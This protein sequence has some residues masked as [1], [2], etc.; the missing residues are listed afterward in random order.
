MRTSKC[1]SRRSISKILSTVVPR[2]PAEFFPLIEWFPLRT[3][4]ACSV[5][6]T[7][8]FRS[9]GD[10]A[11]ESP[12]IQSTL[13]RK[14]VYLMSRYDAIIYMVFQCYMQLFRIQ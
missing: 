14:C 9:W 7:V 2:R 3:A 5:L 6:M 11:T 1:G 13:W 8:S 12:F 10:R 4:R